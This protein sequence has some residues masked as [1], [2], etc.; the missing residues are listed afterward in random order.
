MKT[1]EP[2]HFNRLIVSHIPVNKGVSLYSLN[3]VTKYYLY[4]MIEYLDG[5]EYG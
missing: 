3:D 2:R 4:Y 5:H 1:L